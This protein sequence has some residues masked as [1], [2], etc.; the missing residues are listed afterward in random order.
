MR[1]GDFE[2]QGINLFARPLG[3]VIYLMTS[4]ITTPERV[5]KCEEILFDCLQ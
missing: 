2:S 1:Y 3:N 5:R 4:Q